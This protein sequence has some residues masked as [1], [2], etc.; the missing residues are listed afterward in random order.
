MLHIPLVFCVAYPVKFS[1][2][3]T[4]FVSLDLV[5]CL[6]PDVDYVFEDST[7]LTV[8]YAFPNVYL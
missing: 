5:L 6:V 8:P 3:V 1:V 7:F 4:Y 2:C